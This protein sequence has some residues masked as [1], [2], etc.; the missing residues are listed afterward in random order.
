M[1]FLTTIR[2]YLAA[3]IMNRAFGGLRGGTIIPRMVG[4]PFEV[5]ISRQLVL[6]KRR[7]REGATYIESF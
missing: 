5:S 3:M 4:C 6:P 7:K 1:D 2:L